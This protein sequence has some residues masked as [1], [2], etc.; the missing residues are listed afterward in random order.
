MKNLWERGFVILE[1]RK[2]FKV[3]HVILLYGN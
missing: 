1:K 2:V 3:L